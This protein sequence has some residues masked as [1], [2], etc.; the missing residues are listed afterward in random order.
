MIYVM[1]IKIDPGPA[2]RCLCYTDDGDLTGDTLQTADNLTIKCT[3]GSIA[4]KPGFQE[5]KQLG[6]DGWV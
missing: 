4:M 2:V 5:T 6:P 1:D 3:V